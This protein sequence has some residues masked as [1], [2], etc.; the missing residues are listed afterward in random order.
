MNKIIALL[1]TLFVAPL[2]LVILLLS[3]PY[4]MHYSYSLYEYIHKDGFLMQQS[5]T[6]DII[7][8]NF[9]NFRIY[10]LNEHWGRTWG[11]QNRGF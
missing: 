5:E 11:V 4:I 2:I 10:N 7:Y 6:K 1:I 8:R 9:N 3:F